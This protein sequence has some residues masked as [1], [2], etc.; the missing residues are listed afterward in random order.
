MKPKFSLWIPCVSLPVSSLVFETECSAAECT[1]SFGTAKE[2]WKMIYVG[3][4]SRKWLTEVWMKRFSH[5]LFVVTPQQWV[6]TP[7]RLEESGCPE[8]HR[9]WACSQRRLRTKSSGERQPWRQQMH[10]QLHPGTEVKVRRSA[11]TTSQFLHHLYM[12]MPVFCQ[13]E[14]TDLTVHC[15]THMKATAANGGG[16]PYCSECIHSANFKIE[17]NHCWWEV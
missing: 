4:K 6:Q 7:I 16:G 2:R 5:Y 11:S 1:Y 3:M 12:P 9:C 8:R 14:I 10:R 17:H 13:T 15:L